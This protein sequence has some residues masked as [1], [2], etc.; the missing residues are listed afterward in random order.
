MKLKL[1]SKK[2][3]EPEFYQTNFD[4]YAIGK[5]KFQ[6]YMR[7]NRQFLDKATENEKEFMLFMSGFY[8]GVNYK[9]GE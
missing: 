1:K 7:L 8:S 6:L 3:K 4:D 9:K 2:K 5:E